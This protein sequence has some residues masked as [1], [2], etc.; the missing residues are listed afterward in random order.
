[1]C[2]WFYHGVKWRHG[3]TRSRSCALY[4]LTVRYS[5]RHKQCCTH[6]LISINMYVTTMTHIRSGEES[7]CELHDCGI[8]RIAKA[9][10][11]CCLYMPA[12]FTRLLC[13]LGGGGG[14]GGMLK[15]SHA[16]TATCKC[17]RTNQ[18]RPHHLMSEHPV[19]MSNQ[20]SV[21][22]LW[23]QEIDPHGLRRSDPCIK[24]YWVWIHHCH[25]HPLPAANCY[26]NSWLGVD[27]DDLM[28]FKNLKNAFW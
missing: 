24:P 17:T 6:S 5:L 19:L 16:T 11:Y 22:Y 2:T 14:G 15:M 3:E 18:A 8:C 26:S 12:A 20:S 27:E 21:H 25:L 1:M 13:R 9:E 28:W 10:I 23:I 7:A 4:L